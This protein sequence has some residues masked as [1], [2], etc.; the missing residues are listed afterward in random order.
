MK[1]PWRRFEKHS[2]PPPGQQRKRCR[3]ST[4]WAATLE[5][6]GRME[7]T[8]EAYRWIRREDPDYRDVAQRIQHLSSKRWSAS[9]G[10]AAQPSWVTGVLRSWQS[11]LGTTK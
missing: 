3:F 10:R 4:C 9:G 8:L 1:M 6:L 7:E 11:L 5:L 2:N